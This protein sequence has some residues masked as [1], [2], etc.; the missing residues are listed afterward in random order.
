MV[1]VGARGDRKRREWDSNMPSALI[2]SRE[3]RSLAHRWSTYHRRFVLAIGMLL[4]L[5]SPYLTIRLQNSG[6][7]TIGETAMFAESPHS[8]RPR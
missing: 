2:L 7:L 8:A 5:A 1:E 4:A 3:L 6:F